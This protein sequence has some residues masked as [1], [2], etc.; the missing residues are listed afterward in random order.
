[1]HDFL[2]RIDIGLAVSSNY[3]LTDSEREMIAKEEQAAYELHISEI[4]SIL[5]IYK[6]ELSERG[7]WT[8]CIV[9]KSGMRFR[10]NLPGYY[11]PGGFSSQFHIA[12][13]L[14]LGRI[15]PAGDPLQSFYDNDL[16]KNVMIGADFNEQS[17]R[18]FVEQTVLDYVAPENLILTKDQYDRIRA[19]YP[20]K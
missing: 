5:N 1:M 18:Q 19:V 9:G 16:E 8:E 12:G 17:F 10:Y 7:F 4:S 20:H 13:P 2:K 11:G 14:V 3:R 15:N 6:H